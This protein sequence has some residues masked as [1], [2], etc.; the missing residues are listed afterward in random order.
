MKIARIDP[1]T[2]KVLGW[3]DLTGILSAEDQQG[4]NEMNGIAYDANGDRLFGFHCEIRI[5]PAEER[6]GS[7]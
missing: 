6:A 3:I 4:A 1:K 7:V 5:D 2:G